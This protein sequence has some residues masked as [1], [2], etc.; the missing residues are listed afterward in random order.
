MSDINSQNQV[1]PIALSNRRAKALIMKM[2]EKEYRDGLQ[3]KLGIEEITHHGDVN[4]DGSC[5]LWA[6]CRTDDGF[7]QSAG[8][9]MEKTVQ[10][11]EVLVRNLAVDKR[12]TMAVDAYEAAQNEAKRNAII[13]LHNKMFPD[14]QINPELDTVLE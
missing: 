3:F 4:E 6:W 12:L 13:E 5:C 8:K 9:F 1:F 11:D 10:L 7:C 14:H 2:A